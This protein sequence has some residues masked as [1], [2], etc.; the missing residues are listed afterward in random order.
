MKKHRAAF[1]KA[2]LNDL[3]MPEALAVVWNGVKEGTLSIE[4]IIHFDKV[5]GLNL[6]QRDITQEPIPDF[7]QKLVDERTLAREAKDFKRSDELRDQIFA[8]G[9]T[10]EDTKDGQKVKRK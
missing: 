9:Y 10:L 7:I 5:L 1:D 2:L 6:H 3:N 4:T 8:E